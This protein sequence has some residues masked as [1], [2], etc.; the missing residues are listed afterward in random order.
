MFLIKNFK[1]LMD[2]FDVVD[3]PWKHII[4]CS[5]AQCVAFFPSPQTGNETENQ[6]ENQTGDETVNEVGDETVNEV[7]DET[8]RMEVEIR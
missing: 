7:G 1:K 6:T 5:C 8:S 3:S 4:T 2:Y